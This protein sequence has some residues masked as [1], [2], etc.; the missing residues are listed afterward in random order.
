MVGPCLLPFI[1]SL[2]DEHLS[3]WLFPS[4][5][6]RLQRALMHRAPWLWGMWPWKNVEEGLW[7]QSESSEDGSFLSTAR[8]FSRVAVSSL[9][10]CWDL[11]FKIGQISDKD[12]LFNWYRNSQGHTIIL[13]TQ[14]NYLLI[15]S[16]LERGLFVCFGPELWKIKPGCQM[17]CILS[18]EFSPDVSSALGQRKGVWGGSAQC[19]WA[20][21]MQDITAPSLFQ[22]RKEQSPHFSFLILTNN[23]YDSFQSQTSFLPRLV[24]NLH[25]GCG[26]QA[27][28]GCRKPN[29]QQ[30][31]TFSPKPTDLLMKGLSFQN[32]S[33]LV[34]SFFCPTPPTYGPQLEAWCFVWNGQWHASACLIMAGHIHPHACL[35]PNVAHTHSPSETFVC[36]VWSLETDNMKLGFPPTPFWSDP[37]PPQGASLRGQGMDT[38]WLTFHDCRRPCWPA[39]LLLI[40]KSTCRER[41][42]LAVQLFI[43]F[44]SCLL[45]LSSMQRQLWF[46]RD[47]YSSSPLPVSIWRGLFSITGSFD[48]DPLL[49]E[50]VDLPAIIP[51]RPI[52]MTSHRKNICQLGKQL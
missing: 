46:S 45:V 43:R 39:A 50:S 24:N 22:N 2:T 8:F 48:C 27:L 10:F 3:H 5:E 20:Q 1:S 18:L 23:L 37:M 17:P 19:S 38:A 52:Q 35:W 4:L 15:K 40:S 42:Q 32:C 33:Q 14:N 47:P 6:I 21:G 41:G 7:N 44:S 25:F 26:S 12:T 36:S 29:L 9:L 31:N 51:A 30:E 16:G 11:N 34:H 49:S 28:T 13:K